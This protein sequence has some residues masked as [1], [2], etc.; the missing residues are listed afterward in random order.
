[1]QQTK[2][3]AIQNC[4]F[5]IA[6]FGLGP[7]ITLR[8]HGVQL[9][10]SGFDPVDTGINKFNWRDILAANHVAKFASC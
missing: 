4:L 10:I 9:P 2:F 5:R 1:M 7:V 3:L 8:H 6:R